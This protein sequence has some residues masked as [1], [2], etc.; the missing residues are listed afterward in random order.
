[1][2]ATGLRPRKEGWK[3]VSRHWH[4]SLPMVITCPSSNSKLFSKEEDDTTVAISCSISR[5]I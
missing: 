4:L 3:S 1:M 2:D 5:A